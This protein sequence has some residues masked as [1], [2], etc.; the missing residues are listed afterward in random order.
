[1][2]LNK[3]DKII[4]EQDIAGYNWLGHNYPPPTKKKN[5]KKKINVP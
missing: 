3:H 2:Y 4:T 5:N 1:M